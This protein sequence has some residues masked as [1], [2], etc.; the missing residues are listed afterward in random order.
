MFFLG[1]ELDLDQLKK[2]WKIT[3]PIAIVSIILPCKLSLTNGCSKKNGQLFCRNF[4]T[5]N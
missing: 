2:N 5:P 1:L 3:L 4:L